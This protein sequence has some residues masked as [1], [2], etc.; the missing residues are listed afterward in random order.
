MVF[1]TALDAE[2]AILLNHLRGM[3]RSLAKLKPEHWDWTFAPA[4]PTPR[5]IA[6]H[7]LA[8]LQCDRQHINTPDCT[9][10]KLVPEPPSDPAELC[11]ALEAEAD[12]WERLL[13]SLKCEDLTRKSVQFGQPGAYLNV[14]GF[15]AHMVQ[16]VI[17]KH[18]QFST[19]FFG[20]GYDGDGPYDAP[21]PNPIYKKTL[22]IG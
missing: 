14:N 15:I 20:L 8:W 19:L 21:Y 10:H 17:Y 4:A 16:N 22:G 11:R 2:A 7:T 1:E 9:T 18:G 13:T 12:E 6:S 5:I 3:A